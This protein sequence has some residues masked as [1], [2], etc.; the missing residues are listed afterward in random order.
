MNKKAINQILS[1]IC[2]VAFVAALVTPLTWW[3]FAAAFVVYAVAYGPL[4]G[5]P[6]VR[7]AFKLTQKR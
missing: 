7:I 3:V 4:T 1:I 5:K 2:I 6:F